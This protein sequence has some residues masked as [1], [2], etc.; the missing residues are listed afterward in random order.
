MAEQRLSK[1]QKWILETCFK[2][3]VMHDRSELKKLKICPYYNE[4]KCPVWSKKIRDVNNGI[5]HR[6]NMENKPQY[7]N[8]SCDVYE[9]YLEDILLNYFDMDYS[10][11]KDVLYRV[12][13][14]KMTDDTNKNY[15]T[16]SRT[17]KNLED[18]GLIFR[19]KYAEYSTQINLTDKGKNIA[20]SLLNVNENEI[21]EP[22]ML[23]EQDCEELKVKTEAE[24]ERLRKLLYS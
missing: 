23:S 13:R 17:L 4:E 7:K 1:V 11:E 8:D 15:S 2:I 9:M 5:L 3:T 20:M 6:C 18:K 21:N 22:P 16:L 12:A 10:F 14:I 24:I 19:W